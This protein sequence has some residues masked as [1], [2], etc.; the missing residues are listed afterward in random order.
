MGFVAIFVLV[1][2]FGSLMLSVC[3]VICCVGL[4]FGW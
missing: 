2:M 1:L 3:Y 4:F